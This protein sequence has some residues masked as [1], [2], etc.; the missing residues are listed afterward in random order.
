M[1][2]DSQIQRDRIEAYAERLRQEGTLQYIILRDIALALD[3]QLARKKPERLGQSLTLDKNLVKPLEIYFKEAFNQD[4]WEASAK[5]ILFHLDDENQTHSFDPEDFEMLVLSSYG[6]HR[7][8]EIIW[9]FNAWELSVEILEGLLGLTPQK[10]ASIT[11]RRICQAKFYEPFPITAINTTVYTASVNTPNFWGVNETSLNGR[12]DYSKG[13]IELQIRDRFDIT[14]FAEINYQAKEVIAQQFGEEA[15]KLHYALGVIAFRKEEPWADEITVSV[16]K[17]LADFGDDKKKNRYIPKSSVEESNH[18]VCY[19]SKEERL[20]RIAHQARL[21]KRIEVWVPAWRATKKRTF[22]VEMSNLWDIFSITEITQISADGEKKII[23]IEI[24]YKPGIWFR[25]FANQ[26]LRKFGY[27]TSEALKLDPVQ[28]RMALR[29]AYFALSNPQQHKS[30][31]YKIKTLLK[32]I[33]CESEI[34]E[35]WRNPRTAWNLERSFKRGLKTLGKFQH[36]YRFE[37]APDAPMWAKPDSKTKKPE[38]WFEIWLE[39]SGTLHQPDTLPVREDALAEPE[40]LWKPQTARKSPA[41]FDPLIF[42]QQ[43]RQA[44]KEKGDTL[45]AMAEF[46]EISKTQLSQIEKGCY[47]TTI[48]PKVKA[49]IIG[50]LGLSEQTAS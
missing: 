48:N 41:I 8:G 11:E 3:L 47:P 20:K 45:T 23:D 24:T 4:F 36:P 38:G 13:H 2:D 40:K 50:Y 10:P 1:L 49:R 22:E 31:I 17:L 35:A 30:S 42:G 34:E 14:D 9:S 6:H 27:I 44:R 25:R 46:L 43:V 29:L 19:V 7:A 39:L 32:A 28:D 37:L 12:K 33:G 18:P 21:L 16:S 5:K 15:L 26:D